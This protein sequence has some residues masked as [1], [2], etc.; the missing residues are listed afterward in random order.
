M[1]RFILPGITLLMFTLFFSTTMAAVEKKEEK[2]LTIVAPWRLKG[3]DLQRSGFIFTRMG[4]VETLTT[5][6]DRGRIVGHLIESWSV[7]PDRLTWTFTLR[8][9]VTFHDQTPLTARAVSKSLNLALK[10]KSILTRARIKEIIPVSPQ[11][12]RITTSQ[13]F[14]PLPS[15]LAHYSAG[16][17]SENSFDDQGHLRHVIGTGPYILTGHEGDSRFDFQ[18]NPT[19]W[20][21]KPQVQHA[22]YLAVPEAGRRALMIRDGEADMAFTLSPTVLSQLRAAG[23]VRVVTMTIPRTRLLILNCSQP[24]FS[25]I[26]SR[27]ALSLAIDRRGIASSMLRHPNS[28]ATQLL[29]YSAA[30]WHTPELKPL[31]YNLLQARK[32]LEEEGWQPGKDGILQKNGQRFEF[33]LRTYSTRPMLPV[34][35]ASL[36]EQLRRIGIK[37]HV[38]VGTGSDY[39]AHRA[40]D[41]LQAA[42]VARNFALIPDAIGTIYNDFGP[43]PGNWGAFHWQSEKINGMLDRYLQTFDENQAKALR[44]E[45]LTVLQREL[46]VIPVSWYEHIIGLSDRIEGVNIDPHELK[47]Y[48]NG[49]RWA[50]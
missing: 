47:S 9:N 44:L 11:I 35:A 27:Q 42:L 36:K 16:I 3:M 18:A 33:E 39:L 19:Y 14:A 17:V 28:M 38:V 23:T 30:M 1:K 21:E 25:T 22:R 4:C 10:N 31:E 48:L 2:V 8:S 49:V 50:R 13:P 40:D 26:R 46:P 12:L 43:D 15:Y 34:I 6:D 24:F 32:M 45:I 37:V 7:S 29:P 20:G 41:T 5:T